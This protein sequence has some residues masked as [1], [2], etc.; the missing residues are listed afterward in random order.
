M[1]QIPDRQYSEQ[2]LADL[3]D[4]G[5]AGSED[6]DFYLGLVGPAPQTILDLGCGTGL[7]S[8]ELAKRG[9][10]V[11]GVDPAEA[12]LNVA[13]RAPGGTQVEWVLDNAETYRSEQRFDFIFMTGHAFQVLLSD[14]QIAAAF[15]TLYCHLRDEGRAVFESRNPALDWDAIWPRDYTMKHGADTIRAVRRMTDTSKAPHFLSFAWDYDFGDDV[16][17]SDS[18]L[19]FLTASEILT[20]ASDAGLELMKV[21]GDWDGSKFDPE[22]SR[23]MIFQFQRAASA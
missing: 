8:L 20:F 18:T 4:L 19:R 23:E 16:I 3:Y 13:R 21:S 5:N 1:P 7:L 14:A 10:R 2:R 12:M 11:T 6:R 17:T 15:E 22:V 9:H